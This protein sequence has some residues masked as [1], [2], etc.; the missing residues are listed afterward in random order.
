MS[1]W[2][3][4]KDEIQFGSAVF[5]RQI[6]VFDIEHTSWPGFMESGCNMPGKF[7]EIIQIGAVKI[8]MQEGM[9]EIDSFSVLIKPVLNPVLSDY[10]VELTGITQNDVNDSGLTLDNALALFVQFA[11]SCTLMAL[12]NDLEIISTNCTL[13]GIPY[14]LEDVDSLNLRSM[15]AR[16]LR[17][18]PDTIMSCELPQTFSFPPPGIKH[19]AVAD[20]R[21]I[22]EALRI[23]RRNPGILMPAQK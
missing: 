19:H 2:K 18:D 5:E 17:K 9:P 20:S 14:P 3:G 10:I 1:K 16:Y 6:V 4:P 21:C 7:A 8:S 12:G 13:K 22:A 11:E 23:M 15:F